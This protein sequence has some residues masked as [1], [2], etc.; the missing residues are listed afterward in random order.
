M[1]NVA[2]QLLERESGVMRSP[3]PEV[4]PE[5]SLH[6]DLITENQVETEH[7]V[8][9]ITTDLAIEE[10]QR[11]VTPDVVD[12]PQ[13]ALKSR[14][15]SAKKYGAKAVEKYSRIK[16]K[17]MQPAS[18]ISPQQ[19]TTREETPTQPAARERNATVSTRVRQNK[20]RHTS[21][22][23]DAPSTVSLHEENVANNAQ[24]EPEQI[25]HFVPN[26]T[27]NI[28]GNVE[29]ER[30]STAAKFW[31]FQS[32][33]Q[34]APSKTN[35]KEPRRFL[36]R[37]KDAKRVEFESPSAMVPTTG[38]E[39]RPDRA[40]SVQDDAEIPSPAMN[41]PQRSSTKRSRAE[42]SHDTTDLQ[43]NEGPARKRARTEEQ[44]TDYI[45][46][47]EAEDDDQD[48]FVPN[49]HPVDEQAAQRSRNAHK[50]KRRR[51]ETPEN[52]ET[53]MVLRNEPEQ[54]SSSLLPVNQA[55]RTGPPIRGPSSRRSASTQVQSTNGDPSHSQHEKEAST[56]APIDL[57]GDNAESD[58]DGEETVEE[59]ATRKA[60]EKKQQ[61]SASKQL[62]R[63]LK[64]KKEVRPIPHRQEKR[65]WTDEEMDLVVKGVVKYGCAWRKIQEVSVY[66]FCSA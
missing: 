15:P 3:T 2:Q 34:V 39:S 35:V 51:Q 16:S 7:S 13:V 53:A 48:D 63:V 19:S 28:A 62:K 38:Q 25:E 42:S 50:N 46:E 60:K 33:Q 36:D 58:F 6:Q 18:Q 21:D 55:A 41:L 8:D 23:G 17:T 27:N 64:A 37:Q 4:I 5:A 24:E 32:S 26:D 59:R 52:N 57:D 30:D 14:R 1:G 66:Y 20:R 61:E 45:R 49:S 31:A 10:D 12:R 44:R 65:I 40:I 29:A 22:E 54:P 9:D 47:D 11:R 56:V 43:N